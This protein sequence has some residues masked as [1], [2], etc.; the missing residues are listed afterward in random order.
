VSHPFTFEYFNG[1]TSQGGYILYRDF[2]RNA[3]L[4]ADIERNNVKSVLEIGCGRGYVLRKLEAKGIRTVGLDV[5]EYCFLT[6]ASKNV[7]IYDIR[8]TPWPFADKEFDLCLS[9]DVLDMLTVDELARVTQECG[10]V[11]RASGH[12][13]ALSNPDPLLLKGRKR[14]LLMDGWR[15]LFGGVFVDT[16]AFDAGGFVNEYN[17]GVI[18]MNLGCGVNMFRQGWLNADLLDQSVVA[19]G[20]SYL[21]QRGDI[22]GVW[23]TRDDSA[24]AIAVLNVVH[25]LDM[26][27]VSQLL[28]QC[29]RV[30]MAGGILRISVPDPDRVTELFSSGMIRHLLPASVKGEG[31]DEVLDF[32]CRGRT[33]WSKASLVQGLLEKKFCKIVH[34]SPFDSQMKFVSDF[35]VEGSPETSVTVECRK[36][37][38]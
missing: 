38:L 34:A 19:T 2:M 9:V 21:F 10:R 30:M 22:R 28:D 26:D 25:E 31:L 13:V 27:Q 7:R 20:E 5:S 36:L 35:V 32:F 1:G 23:G 15:A 3:S 11:A 14:H 4:A 8:N 12:A 33:R 24:T 17:S 6:R 37:T 29:W 16:A 18:K